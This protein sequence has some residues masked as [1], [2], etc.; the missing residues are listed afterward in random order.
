[1]VGT[2]VRDGRNPAPYAAA[3]A[4]TVRPAVQ[5]SPSRITE[6][7]RE[8]AAVPPGIPDTRAENGVPSWKRRILE[9]LASE[10]N[11][12]GASRGARV[13][14]DVTAD[15]VDARITRLARELRA[16]AE[17]RTG[18]DQPGAVRTGVVVNRAV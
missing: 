17:I 16:R 15:N 14:D 5:L 6:R 7:I 12:R 8:R 3:G 18:Y 2:V 10:L 13:G 4:T 11:R 1:M 9:S